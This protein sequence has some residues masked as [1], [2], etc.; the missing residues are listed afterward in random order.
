MVGEGVSKHEAAPDRQANLFP[1]GYPTTVELSGT[2][3]ASFTG[4]YLRGNERVTISGTVPWTRTDTNMFR[5]EI[6]KTNL[7]D[8]IICTARGG[9]P[10]GG[11]ALR[12][13]NPGVVG[14]RFNMERGWSVEPIR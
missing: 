13:I 2:V 6:R 12:N 4:H 1:G 3:G 8:T 5:L 7:G 10:R 11:T 14:V 9:G